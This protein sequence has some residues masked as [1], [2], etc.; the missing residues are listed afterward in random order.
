MINALKKYFWKVE[1]ME[2]SDIPS[3]NTAK[4][5][6]IY[7]AKVIGILTYENSQWTFEY[8]KEYQQNPVIKPILDFPDMNKTYKQ[9]EL[10]PFFATRIPTLNQPFHLKKINKANIADNNTASLLKLFGNKTIT[11]PFLLKALF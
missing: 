1:G 5:N 7:D 3:S 8:S 6:L 4:F 11:N 10:W 2:Y 9:K